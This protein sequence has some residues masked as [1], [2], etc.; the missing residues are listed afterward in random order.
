[1]PHPSPGTTD[2]VP[3]GLLRRVDW[4]IVAL[5]CVIGLA[6]VAPADGAAAEGVSLTARLAVGLLFF[7]YG[8]RLSP[9]ERPWTAY[10]TGDC[11]SPSSPSPSWS[12]PRPDWRSDC[13]RR[14]CSALNWPP[15]SSS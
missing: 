11:T 14:P 13:C 12:S 10:G 7:L 6:A 2:P 8:A 9:P 5:F 15:V 1:M 4:Y 3:R